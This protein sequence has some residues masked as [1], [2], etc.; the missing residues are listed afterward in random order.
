MRAEQ[1]NMFEFIYDLERCREEVKFCKNCLAMSLKPN[2]V[3]Y[4]KGR[5]EMAEKNFRQLYPCYSI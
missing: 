1:I 3:K 4:W 2:K 5:V